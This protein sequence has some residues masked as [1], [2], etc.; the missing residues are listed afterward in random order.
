ML[1]VFKAEAVGHLRNGLARRQPVLGKPDDEAADV[2]ARR[3]AGRL[4]DDITEVV[5]RHAEPVGAILHGG[6]AERQL[7]L[8]LEI[9]AQ[10]AV[11]T[12]EDVGVLN[13]AG[14]E[15]AVV[16]PLAEVERQL[17]VADED[18]LLQFVGL[19]RK[20]LPYLA[21]QRD[22]EVVLLVGHV[23]GL[24]DTVVEEGILPD[25]PFER[26]AVQQVG[27]EQERPARNRH[28]FAVVLLAAHLPGSHAEQRPLVVIVLAA[29]IIEVHVGIV[30]EEQ[31]VHA[32]I[33]QAVAYG[34]HLGIVDDADQRVLLRASDVAAVIIHV[35]YLQNLAHRSFRLTDTKITFFFP[36]PIARSLIFAIFA[37]IKQELIDV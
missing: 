2:V 8:V 10:Q 3:V 5:G 24:V 36:I 17:D 13:L 15:L 21:H 26:E 32:V 28:P 37:K 4:L 31:P 11:E 35:P 22:K 14:D 9:V 16:E 12:D 34:R 33:V 30:P 1:G 18:G 23:Q 20:L 27:M 29:A 7:E 19:P 6:Q 25:A